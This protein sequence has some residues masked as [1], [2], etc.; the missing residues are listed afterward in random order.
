MKTAKDLALIRLRRLRWMALGEG[1]TLLILLC[2]AV[3]L[4]H[5]FGYTSAVSVMGPIH[6]V[7]FLLY[8]WMV[9]DAVSIDDWSKEELARMAVAALLPFGAL[10]SSGM[11]RRKAGEIAAAGDKGLTP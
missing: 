2:I 1:A 4:K 5:L 7:A 6:G 9:F 3:P 8:V 10:L 11:L